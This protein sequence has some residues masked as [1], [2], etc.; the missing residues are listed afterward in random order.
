MD[1][2]DSVDEEEQSTKLQPVNTVSYVAGYYSMKVLSIIIFGIISLFIDNNIIVIV[3]LFSMGVVMFFVNKNVIGLHLAGLKW[4]FIK[5]NE[6]GDFVQYYVR[7]PSFV[8]DSTKSNAFWLGFFLS[9]IFWGCLAIVLLIF[10]HFTRGFS[11]LFNLALEIINLYFFSK[12]H[13]YAKQASAYEVASS[14]LE[15]VT[16]QSFSLNTDNDLESPRRY[17]PDTFAED[18]ETP[19]MQIPE[20][21]SSESG[22]NSSSLSLPGDDKMYL[23]S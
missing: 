10:F 3:V 6:N 17:I 22:E 14:L 23:S 16:D 4:N 8:P 20:Y 7:P 1:V 13:I 18:A 2:V 15:S 19:H 11:S 21:M 9:I 12:A 5:P